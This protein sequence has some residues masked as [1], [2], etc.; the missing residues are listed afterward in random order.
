MPGTG[1][2]SPDAG[3]SGCTA[4]PSNSAVPTGC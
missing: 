4:S 3:R 1:W 2:P